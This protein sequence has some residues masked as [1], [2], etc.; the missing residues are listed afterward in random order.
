MEKLSGNLAVFADFDD[1]CLIHSAELGD[2]RVLV[3]EPALDDGVAERL[4]MAFR[5]Q[6]HF[7]ELMQVLLDGF[8]R[9]MGHD[10]VFHVL[11]GQAWSVPKATDRKMRIPL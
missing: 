6:T 11:I 8:S 3:K 5:N 10:I 2:L 4:A 9:A 1:L 7:M